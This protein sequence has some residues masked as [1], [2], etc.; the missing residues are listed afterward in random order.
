MFEQ[1]AAAGLNV[2]RTFAHT[3]DPHFPLQVGEDLGGSAKFAVLTWPTAGAAD[4]F[5]WLCQLTPAFMAAALLP[6]SNPPAC[7]Q[8]KPGEYD[9]E[10]FRGLDVVIAEAQRAGLRVILSFVDNWKYFG[11]VDEVSVD[12]WVR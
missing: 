12:G 4:V 3:T 10:V 11:G 6:C 5:E 2:V 9:E 7:P 8:T 1:A